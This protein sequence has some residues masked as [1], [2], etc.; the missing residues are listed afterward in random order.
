[1]LEDRVTRGW[2]QRLIREYPVNLPTLPFV[3]HLL[4]SGSPSDSLTC[5]TRILILTL[6]PVSSNRSSNRRS[7]WW[8]IIYQ[9]LLIEKRAEEIN[10]WKIYSSNRCWVSFPGSACWEKVCAWRLLLFLAWYLQVLDGVFQIL[11]NSFT[12]WTIY[13]YIHISP[14][15]GQCFTNNYQRDFLSHYLGICLMNFNNYFLLY[16]IEICWYIILCKTEGII[17][18]KN[19]FLADIC[20]ENYYNT[21]YIW[22]LYWFGDLRTVEQE[23]KKSKLQLYLSF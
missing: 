6:R 17:K 16:L 2:A 13:Y 8:I 12:Y 9:H 10:Y 14:S 3:C 7:S 23:S 1:M 19:L 18:R 21:I 5:W 11:V 15:G 4:P 20:L 22:I